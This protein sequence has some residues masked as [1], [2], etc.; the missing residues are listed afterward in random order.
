MKKIKL[1]LNKETIKV[2]SNDEV[3]VIQGGVPTNRTQ[4]DTGL[5]CAVNS[6]LMRCK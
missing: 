6:I 1:T 4:D 2:L 3:E 5:I